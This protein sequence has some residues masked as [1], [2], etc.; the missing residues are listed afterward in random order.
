MYEI[1]IGRFNCFENEKG[2]TIL[3]KDIFCQKLNIK[4]S[5]FTKKINK[6]AEQGLVQ[7][8]IFNIESKKLYEAI[9][10]Q[11]Q[12]LIWDLFKEIYN[13]DFFYYLD[14]KYFNK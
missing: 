5:Q 12:D 14:N 11:D 7:Y 13:H 10:Q 4:N 9:L 6:F 3:T 2:A 1:I 8:I